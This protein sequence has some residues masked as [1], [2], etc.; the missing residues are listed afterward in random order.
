MKDD[1]ASLRVDYGTHELTQ[2]AAG[3]D[4]MLLFRAW[5]DDARARP[6]VPEP[7]AMS[8]ATATADGVPSV[9]MV[10]L[11]DVDVPRAAFTWFTN[12]RSRKARE[13]LERREPVAALAWWWPG[14]DERPGRQVRAAGRVEVVDRAAT[15]TYF[16]SR[17]RAA[18]I[19]AI[20]SHQSQPV[21]DRSI[22]DARAAAIG[23]ADIVLPEDWGGLRLIADELEFW[24]GRSGRLHDRIAFLRARDGESTPPVATRVVDA[25]G[26]AWHRMRLEP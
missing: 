3:N 2:L 11:K 9:R 5:F 12:L 7:N 15:Q 1:L 22:L 25:T 24:Q 23:D 18:R 8:L 21:H 4:P 19:G 26:T 14:D 13:I 20:A 6:S 10:L 17:P 16:D